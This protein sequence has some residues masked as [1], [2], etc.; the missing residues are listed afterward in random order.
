MADLLLTDL[1]RTSA[2]AVLDAAAALLLG[3]RLGED[4]RAA[5]LGPWRA[6]AGQ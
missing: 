3:E 2:A 5:R 4:D 6:V 1:R